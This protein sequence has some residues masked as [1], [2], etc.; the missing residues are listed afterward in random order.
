MP[1]ITRFT[2]SGNGISPRGFT[3]T[4]FLL[5]R[6]HVINDFIIHSTRYVITHF[7]DN[8]GILK[9]AHC[10]FY[11]R[12]FSSWKLVDQWFY[13]LTYAVPVSHRLYYTDV[14]SFDFINVIRYSKF[15]EKY[16]GT[17]KQYRRFRVPSYR[18]MHR[19]PLAEQ[20][21]SLNDTGIFLIS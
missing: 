4:Y 5:T 9:A 19:Y 8:F 6:M 14:L 18:M 7:D 10:L 17:E 2:C 3:L 12:Y 15:K 1:N 11:G 21:N 13:C 16:T 20:M